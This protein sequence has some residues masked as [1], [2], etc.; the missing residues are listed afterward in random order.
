MLPWE[1]LNKHRHSWSAPELPAAVPHLA[2]RQS[3]PLSSPSTGP[4][5]A[6]GYSFGGTRARFSPLRV[7]LPATSALLRC[8]IRRLL[9]WPWSHGSVLRADPWCFTA[10][11]TP[12]CTQQEHLVQCGE[13][14]L[15]DAA[16]RRPDVV[17]S[18]HPNPS[19]TAGQA[20]GEAPS[21]RQHP[22]LTVRRRS[23]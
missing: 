20:W 23:S 3:W 14:A 21:S 15:E 12:C 11:E 1:V 19:G 13:S 16:P 5:P 8:R 2:A 9:F 4:G 17:N 22:E 7:I 6:A 18:N 10:P